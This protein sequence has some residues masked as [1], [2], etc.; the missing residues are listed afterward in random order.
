MPGRPLCP[1]CD[2]KLLLVEVRPINSAVGIHLYE[3]MNC[4]FIRE[5][6]T[7][8]KVK[9]IKGWVIDPRLP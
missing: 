7:L 5:E 4:D 3:R 8:E 6:P 2:A 1:K 9:P